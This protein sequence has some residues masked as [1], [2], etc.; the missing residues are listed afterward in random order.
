MADETEDSQ[1]IRLVYADALRRDPEE[2]D[3]YLDVACA[4]RPALREKVVALIAAHSSDFVSTT[5]V[6]PSPQH[7]AADFGFQSEG[8]TVGPYIIRRELGR[9]GMGVVYLADDTRL[10]RRVAL[11]ALNDALSLEPGGRERLRREARAAA[12]LSHP[13]IATVYAIEEFAG[14]LYIACEY[15]P[16]DP[17]RALIKSGPV[18]ADQVVDIGAQLARAL[19]AAHTAGIVHRDIKPENIVRTPSGVVKVLDFGLARSEAASFLTQAG[20]VLG[21]PSYLAPEQALGHQADFRSDL[22]ALGLVLYELASGVNPFAAST[23]SA[24]LARV[25][26][27]EPLPLSQLQPA[28]V[29]DLERIVA[30]CLQKDPARRYGSTQEL[31]ADLEQLAVELATQKR[32]SSHHSRPVYLT[33]GQPRWWWQVHQLVVS[34]IYA[35]MLYPAWLVRGFLPRPGGM[36]FFLALLAA[37]AAAVTFRLHLWFVSRFFPGELAAQRAR[38][39][40]PT[41]LSDTAFAAC[42]L[43]AAVAMAGDHPEFAVLLVAVAISTL[44]AAFVIEPTTARVAFPPAAPASS[45]SSRG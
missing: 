31:V 3:H 5:T 4:N 6:S 7:R 34:A 40:L 26:E 12:A 19:A 22:F 38:S 18:P 1:L 23:I 11:K 37:T 44:V 39:Q 43:A 21:T 13:G 9:G 24:T 36:L 14:Q 10:S 41:Q 17:L 2:R 32:Q 28:V 42:L 29:A 16:G 45:G 30:T 8:R 35:G 20:V 33:R 27:E 15:V 25:V